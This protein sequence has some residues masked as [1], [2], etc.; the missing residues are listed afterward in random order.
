[1]SNKVVLIS[2]DKD[3]FDYIR[4]KLFM[5]K[6]DE[7]FTFTFD[8]LPEKL[9]LLSSAVIIVNSEQRY[10]NTKDLLKIV[11]DIPIIVSAFNED[12]KF[13]Q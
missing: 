1:M 11:K 9:Y 7:L 6:S 8:E 5:R 12:D 4:A 13:K 3:F 10:E 2:D